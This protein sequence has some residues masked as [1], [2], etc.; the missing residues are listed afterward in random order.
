MKS[1]KSEP[2]AKRARFEVIRMMHRC[3]TSQ[4]RARASGGVHPDYGGAK[5]KGAWSSDVCSCGSPAAIAAGRLVVPGPS[6]LVS[7]TPG[8]RSWCGNLR[9]IRGKCTGYRPTAIQRLRNSAAPR[10][11]RDRWENGGSCV[12]RGLHERSYAAK[13]TFISNG[14]ALTAL[15][16]ASSTG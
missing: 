1:K 7:R 2:T 4:K 11:P 3:E 8:F 9:Q 12:C 16:Q 10:S 15:N 14:M 6:N 5:K 13:A